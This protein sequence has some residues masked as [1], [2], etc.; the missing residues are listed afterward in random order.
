MTSAGT[1]L[2]T[3]YWALRHDVAAVPIERDLV[4]VDGPDAES[5]LQGQL[6]QDMGTL[7]I[8]GPAWSFLL[9]PTG[10][11]DAWLRAS[12]LGAERFVLDVDAG[13]GDAVIARLA[14]FKLRVKADLTLLDGWRAITVRGPNLAA[15]DLDSADAEL[16]VP[17]DWPGVPGGDLFGPQVHAPEGVRAVD[18]AALE[19][20]RIECGIPRMGVELDDKTIPAE[21]GEAVLDRSVSFTKGCYTGQ[22]LVARIDSRGGNVPRR[23]RGLVL[24]ASEPPATGAD[25]EVDGKVVGTVTSAAFSPA[26]QAVVALGFVGRAV[27]PPAAVEVVDAGR[28]IAASVEQ[29]PLLD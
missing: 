26:R 4:V 12:R 1:D 15:V 2:A 10:K 8:T 6:S 20:V 11:V 29:L 22:E 9:Q 27:E 18:P 3:D 25:I 5:F 19:V 21:V 28:R 13:F 16:I 24:D 23:L 17:A 14:R 7:A